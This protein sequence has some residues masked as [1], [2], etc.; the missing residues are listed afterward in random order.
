MKLAIMLAV[1]TWSLAGCEAEEPRTAVDVQNAVQD[2][3]SGHTDLR[4]DQM[5]VHVERI[6]YEGE[7]AM[8]E[9]RIAASE[10]P[11]AEMKMVYFLEL[12]ANGWTVV[13][14]GPATGEGG[15]GPTSPG[16]MPGLP[17]GHPPTAQPNMELPPGHPPT[18]QPR[19]GLPPGH[20]PID[21]ASGQ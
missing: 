9:V 11:E 13:P 19:T 8:A 17:P 21:G 4:A 3:L 6:R 12:G 15:S 20:P 18:V 7:S 2:Y 1:V 14:P 10:D 5:R 16:D